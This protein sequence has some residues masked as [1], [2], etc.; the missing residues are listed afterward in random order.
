MEKRDD[1]RRQQVPPPL[2]DCLHIAKITAGVGN[3]GICLSDE[4][5]GYV[6]HWN[7][8]RHVRC[9]TPSALCSS[10]K[11]RVPSRW[12]GFV[13][14]ISRD[15]TTQVALEVTVAGGHQLVDLRSR[16]GTLRGMIL[17]AARAGKRLQTPLV[18]TRLGQHDR[19]EDLPKE[20]S[21]EPTVQRLWGDL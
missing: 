2:G 1:W 4:H 7:G 18:I 19:I 10:C 6:V 5:S 3:T 11:D 14:M 21:I 17:H 9:K 13:H 20:K 8:K 12:V 16:Y 15:L